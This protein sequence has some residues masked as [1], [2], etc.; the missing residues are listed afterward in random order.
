V[1]PKVAVV[2]GSKSDLP[3]MKRAMEI[4]DMFEVEYE[5][6]I[7]SAHRTPDLLIDYAKGLAKRGVEVVIAGAGM[8]AHLPG[9]IA[10]N[11]LLPVIGVPISHGPLSGLDSLL[12]MVQM[13]SGIPVGTVGID[14][15]AN[16]AI[17]AI[18][19]LALKDERVRERLERYREEEKRRVSLE[20]IDGDDQG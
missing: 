3:K 9:A 2:M 12:S 11:C 17:L 20:S 13:P 15:S 10:A 19:I 7:L 6:R 14:N 18:E 5:A 16:A 4:L 8:A 1:N